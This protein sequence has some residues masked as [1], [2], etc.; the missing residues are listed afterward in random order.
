MEMKISRSILNTY[1]KEKRHI[2]KAKIDMI[3]S[4]IRN[5]D[6]FSKSSLPLA[7]SSRSS[8]AVLTYNSRS[9]DAVPTDQPQSLTIQ[10][11][12]ALFQKNLKQIREEGNNISQIKM[13]N[14]AP[15]DYEGKAKFNFDTIK[16]LCENPLNE[17]IAKRLEEAGVPKDVTFEFDFNFDSRNIEITK[18][19]DEKYREGVEKV[20]ND[21]NGPFRFI[22]CAS[23]VMNGNISSIYYPWISK[24]LESSFGQDINDLYIDENGNLCGVNENLQKALEA[25]KTTK[26]FDAYQMFGFPVNQIEA[27]LKRLISDENI[28]PNISHM[29][30]DGECIYTNDGEFKFG[31]EFDPNLFNEE[32]YIMRGTCALYF[33]V[34]NPNVWLKNYEKFY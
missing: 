5:T 24:A 26:D 31:K 14:I 28:T 19:S 7:Y 16:D 18:I 25:E 20:L 12:L 27:M 9:A 23:R 11:Q 6:T 15:D 33:T 21:S 30:Y 4:R 34:Y 10:E 29:G 8:N 22:S 13:V 2:R 32:K 3:K 17:N 1:A